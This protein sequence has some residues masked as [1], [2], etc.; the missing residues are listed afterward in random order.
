MVSTGINMPLYVSKASL[1]KSNYIRFR[2]TVISH[3]CQHSH[4]GRILLCFNK[5]LVIFLLKFN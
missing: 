2:K 4:T 3:L 5:L 1:P